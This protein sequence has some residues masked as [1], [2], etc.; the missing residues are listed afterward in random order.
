[1][2]AAWNYYG[3]NCQSRITLNVIE[4]DKHDLNIW[5]VSSALQAAL[6]YLHHVQSLPKDTN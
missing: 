3:K 5:N 6:V 4:I 1:M 2:N